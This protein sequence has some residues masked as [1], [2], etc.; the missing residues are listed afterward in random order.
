MDIFGDSCAFPNS[1]R[2]CASTSGAHHVIHCIPLERDF[3]KVNIDGAIIG[4]WGKASYGVPDDAI[5]CH[6]AH[7][8]CLALPKEAARFALFSSELNLNLFKRREKKAKIKPSLD[9]DVYI[10]AAATGGQEANLATDYV[11]KICVD[12][13][14]AWTCGRFAR[15]WSRLV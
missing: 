8:F 3:M 9:I 15:C 6:L 12:S 13:K 10:K 5:K 2:N 7:S 11:L 4:T 14:W 1:L